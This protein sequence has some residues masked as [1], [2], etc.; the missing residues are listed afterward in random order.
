MDISGGVQKRIYLSE[1]YYNQVI[2]LT[3][4]FY[5]HGFQRYFDYAMWLTFMSLQGFIEYYPL[6]LQQYLSQKKVKNKCI[7]VRIYSDHEKMLSTI[8]SVMSSLDVSYIRRNTVI[9]SILLY[10]HYFM[11]RYT[12]LIDYFNSIK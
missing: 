7:A 9:T 2:F 6:F 8:I 4:R 3:K 1:E 10:P 12:N 11:E 5:A